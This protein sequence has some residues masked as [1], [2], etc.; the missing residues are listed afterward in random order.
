MFAFIV[1]KLL[2]NLILPNGELPDVPGN[3]VTGILAEAAQVKLPFVGL[4][5]HAF[6]GNL[7]QGA[8]P[9]TFT[10]SPVADP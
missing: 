1:L 5:Y 2:I 6:I 4:K 7:N 9:G 10:V 3:A 8:C